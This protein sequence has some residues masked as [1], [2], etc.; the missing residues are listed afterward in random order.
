MKLTANDFACPKCKAAKNEPCVALKA[1]RASAGHNRSRPHAA[2]S[3]LVPEAD[4]HGT[5]AG[6][7]RHK[8]RGEECC[9]LCRKAYAAYMRRY[10]KDNPANY[11]SER[12][13]QNARGRA[14]ARLAR[15]HADEFARLY[16]EERAR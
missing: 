2:R 14:L 8:R 1:N 9:D 6:A 3:A 7:Q 13:V 4:E 12:K 5:Y 11:A 15:A 10:R 16:D